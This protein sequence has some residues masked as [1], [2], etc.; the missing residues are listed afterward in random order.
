MKYVMSDIHGNKRRFESILE[1]IALRDEDTLYIL[2]DVIDRHPDGIELLQRIMDMPN[3]Q[4]L[5]GNHEVMMLNALSAPENDEGQ[6]DRSKEMWLWYDNGGQITH[7]DFQQ[8]TNA[9]QDRILQYL[10]E[11]PLN[12]E[13]EVEGRKYLLVHAS[14]ISWY[15]DSDGKY[16]S[17]RDFAVWNRNLFRSADEGTTIIMGHTPTCHMLDESP[18]VLFHDRQ[19]NIIHIDCGSGYPNYVGNE[20]GIHGRLCCL[21][22]DDM[23]IFYSLENVTDPNYVLK[24]PEIRKTA[25]WLSNLDYGHYNFSATYTESSMKLLDEI[26]SLAK[27]IAPMGN[28]AARELYLTADRGPFELYWE[29]MFDSGYPETPQ[30]LHA[31]WEHHFPTPLDWFHCVLL[32]DPENGY[33]GIILNHKQIIEINPRQ[34]PCGFPYDVTDLVHWLLTALKRT[35]DMMRQGSYAEFV[36]RELPIRQKAGTVKRSDLWALYPDLRDEF[37]EDLTQKQVD[38]FLSA[39][40]G[41]PADLE[42]LPGQL[43]SMTANDF[44]TFCSIGYKALGYAVKGQSPQEQYKKYADGRDDGLSEINPDSPEEFHEWLINRDRHGGHP[45]EICRGGNSTHISLYVCYEDTGY[46]LI[47]AGS[48]VSRTIETIKIYLALK[49]KNL[50]VFLRDGDILAQRVTGEELI[51]IVP[52][53]VVPAYCSTWFPGQNVISFMNLPDDAPEKLAEKCTWQEIVLPQLKEGESA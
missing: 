9:E 25:R 21:R 53:G 26:F 41:Q 27:E 50:P 5:L 20:Y 23:E 2:G 22:L 6:D 17:E 11:L 49:A 3:V 31:E 34:E 47:L 43:R 15:R 4:M 48:A 33:K 45:W 14:P 46:S 7:Y 39:I 30:E 36:S 13:I 10:K 51:G 16:N 12:L 32:D 37:F 8:L 19:A 52:E 38:R 40:K 42:E 28:S 18:M 1:Q 35:I 29:M 24:A 44:Y